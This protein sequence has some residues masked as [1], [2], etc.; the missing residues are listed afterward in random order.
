[1]KKSEKNMSNTYSVTW[2]DEA[3]QNLN[4]ITNYLEQNW[5]LKEK[6][7]FFKKLE[8]RLVIIKQYPEIF[9]SSQKSVNIRHSVLTE[10]ITIYYSVEN[11]II[12]IL[13]IFDTRQHPSKLKI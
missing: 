5:S 2:T 11:Q 13:S 8:K 4:G 6:S 1:M 12:R 3:I 10:Q 7:D 9:P